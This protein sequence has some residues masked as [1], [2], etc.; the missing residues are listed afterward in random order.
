[1]EQP[2]GNN[3]VSFDLSVPDVRKQVESDLDA[4]AYSNSSRSAQLEARMLIPR[5]ALTPVLWSLRNAWPV[6]R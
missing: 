3:E 4:S 2:N 6:T 1:M 5:G